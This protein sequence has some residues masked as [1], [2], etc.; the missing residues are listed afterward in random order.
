MSTVFYRLENNLSKVKDNV[1]HVIKSN[2]IDGEKGLSFLFLEKKG[3]SFYMVKAKELEDGSFEV[4]EKKGENEEVKNLS[5]TDVMNMI[6]K[7]KNL[8][9]VNEYVSKER[10]KLKG[11]KRRKST[12]KSSKKMSRSKK[13]VSKKKVSKKKVS[14]KKVS[15]KKV[16]KKKVSKKKKCKINNIVYILFYL[17]HFY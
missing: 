11:G 9:F 13:K 3:D 2:V 15:K 4:K 17:I 6:K 12:K 8:I 5:K 1:K 7:D 14:K 10:S 16:S